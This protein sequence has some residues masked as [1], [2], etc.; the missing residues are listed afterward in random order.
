MASV[1]FKTFLLTAPHI[2]NAR[3]P[4]ILRGRHGIGKSEIV[5]Q[6]E[7]ELDYTDCLLYTSPSP[8]DS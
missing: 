7:E 2:L 3:Y 5:Y 6:I 1:D 4:I 8:R